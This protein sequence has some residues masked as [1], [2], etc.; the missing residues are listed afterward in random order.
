VVGAFIPPL[1]AGGLSCSDDPKKPGY[2]YMPDMYRSPSYETNSSNPLFADSMTERQPGG[3]KLLHV[4]MLCMP[5]LTAC[6]NPFRIPTKATKQQ[7][8]NCTI[9]WR[10]Q[11]QI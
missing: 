3:R 11:K 2:E 1:G 7:E 10:R 4:V 6:L 8:K 5:P 9:R